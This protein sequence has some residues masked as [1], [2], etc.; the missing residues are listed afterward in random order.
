MNDLPISSQYT[1]EY[2]KEQKLSDK[3]V[4]SDTIT[5][6]DIFAEEYAS[7]LHTFFSSGMPANWWRLATYPSINPRQTVGKTAYYFDNNDPLFN[8]DR[9]NAYKTAASN[10]AFSYYFYR[11]MNHVANCTCVECDLR[12]KLGSSNALAF[13]SALAGC[14]LTKVNEVFTSYYKPGCFLSAHHDINKGKIGFTIGLT[15]DW[16]PGYGGLLHF[17]SKDWRSVVKTVVPSY[18]S[19]T[20]LHLKDEGIP[21]LVSTVSEFVTAKRLTITGWYS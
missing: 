19:L 20:L 4:E 14:E 12:A 18:N 10:N 9:L 17:L 13:F 7:K 1:I 21:H 3:L 15:T 2:V 16:Y 5:L 8:I 11:T 6:S